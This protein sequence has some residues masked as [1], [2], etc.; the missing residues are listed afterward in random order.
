[1]SRIQ[2]NEDAIEKM[3]LHL[4]SLGYARDTIK[5]RKRLL[6]QID[7]PFAEVSSRDIIERLHTGLKPNSRRTI[8]AAYRSAFNDLMSMGV[9]SNNPTAGV[10]LGRTGRGQPRPL[11]PAQ[12]ERIITADDCD[13]RA[14]SILGLFAGFRASDVVSL[15]PD[16]LEEAY[17]GWVVHVDGKGNVRV[18]IPAHPM[19]VDL[20]QRRG[21]RGPLWKIQ[22]EH[23]SGRWSRWC[24]EMGMYG[25]RYHQ[26][27]HT[28]ATRL[29]AATGDL[30]LVRDAM[31]HT[32]VATTQI[33]AQ[34]DD[35]KTSAAIVNL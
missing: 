5:A 23:M 11:T 10:R 9:V 26:C 31:R 17:H 34:M 18:P 27:R 19:V 20:I 33:Y 8:L 24:G 3:A 21:P 30:L 7:K 28:F 12:V 1:M 4:E 16:D 6:R 35:A 29:Y 32:T 15:Y 14:W 22:A 2:C 25:L 13:E